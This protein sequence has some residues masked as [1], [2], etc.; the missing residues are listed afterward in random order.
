MSASVASVQA[1]L[2]MVFHP[3]RLLTLLAALVGSILYV[4]IAAVRAVPAV[5]RRKQEARAAWRE[6][7]R[8]LGTLDP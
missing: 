8:R 4:W 7:R 1:L 6:R 3:R 5:R 2:S